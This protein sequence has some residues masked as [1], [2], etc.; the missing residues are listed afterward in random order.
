M[1]DH[2]KIYCLKYACGMQMHTLFV[3]RQK[4]TLMP[5]RFATGRALTSRKLPIAEYLIEALGGKLDTSQV[6]NRLRTGV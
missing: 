1:F 4:K 3:Q 5:E 6:C 2:F